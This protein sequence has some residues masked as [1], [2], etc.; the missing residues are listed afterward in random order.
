MKDEQ[1]IR[2]RLQALEQERNLSGDK[3]EQDWLTTR[4]NELFWVLGVKA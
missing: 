3:Q 4:I 2:S 1:T